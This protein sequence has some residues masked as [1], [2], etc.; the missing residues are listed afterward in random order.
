[1]EVEKHDWAVG[2]AF[3]IAKGSEALHQGL[4]G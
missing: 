3:A 1:M 2:V 4:A